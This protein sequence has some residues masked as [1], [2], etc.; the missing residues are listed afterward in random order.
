M[1]NLNQQNVV[2]VVNMGKEEKER[3]LKWDID[4]KYPKW[5]WVDYKLE[6][7]QFLKEVRGLS[8][9][10]WIPNMIWL[11]NMSLQ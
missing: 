8:V 2:G 1:F 10:V 6:D 11:T 5:A 7:F 4:K 9:V 3:K